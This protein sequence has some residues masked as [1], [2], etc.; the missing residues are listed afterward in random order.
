[1]LCVFT[2]FCNSL[3]Y[4]AISVTVFQPEETGT[5]NSAKTMPT[6]YLFFV[7]LNFDRLTQK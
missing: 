4:L 2:L 1:M 3:F 7:T 5:H 6:L